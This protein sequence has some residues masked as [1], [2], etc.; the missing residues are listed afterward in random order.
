MDMLSAR[1]WPYVSETSVIDGFPHKVPVYYIHDGPLGISCTENERIYRKLDTIVVN[2]TL[3]RNGFAQGYER[4][5]K[6]INAI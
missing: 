1:C 3:N 2:V 6:A 5:R 4:L